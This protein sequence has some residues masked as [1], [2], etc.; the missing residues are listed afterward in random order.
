MKRV[1]SLHRRGFRRF[2]VAGSLNEKLLQSLRRSRDTVLEEESTHQGVSKI[3]EA[4]SFQGFFTYN[5][6][7]EKYDHHDTLY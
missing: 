7:R 1:S 3:T 5:A 4:V 2:L 6:R